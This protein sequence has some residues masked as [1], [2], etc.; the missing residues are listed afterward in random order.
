MA[1]KDL[2]QLNEER[3][4]LIVRTSIIGILANIL[5]AGFKMV[6]GLF[7][8]SIAII[9]DAVN[10]LSDVLSS[11]VTIVGN[12][13]ANKAPDRKHPLGHGRVE[14]ISAL[15]VSAIILYAGVTAAIEAVK[16][17]IN[18]ETPNYTTVTLFII[19]VAV[20][21]KIV[22]GLFVSKQGFSRVW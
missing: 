21:V 10:N 2:N 16:K 4:K 18:P 1:E 14:Y 13:L 6:V 19:A 17:I 3:N 11:L 8:H 5:L 9:L 7:A 15:I 22:L 20:V 12:K